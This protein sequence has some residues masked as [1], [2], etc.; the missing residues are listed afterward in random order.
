GRGLTGRGGAAP[1]GSPRPV[2]PAGSGFRRGAGQGV[3]GSGPAGPRQEVVLLPRPRRSSREARTSRPREPGVTQLS[4]LA[5]EPASLRKPRAPGPHSQVQAGE[6]RL[7][8][9]VSSPPL[10]QKP[11]GWRHPHPEWLFPV[12]VTGLLKE[13]DRGRT[14]DSLQSCTARD[15]C[16]LCYSALEPVDYGLKLLQTITEKSTGHL[17][18]HLKKCVCLSDSGATEMEPFVL[19]PDTVKS[20]RAKIVTFIFWGK[21]NGV[22]VSGS[23]SHTVQWDA[24]SSFDRQWAV[25]F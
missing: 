1:P 16:L 19:A 21:N 11:I 4:V 17:E 14:W 2:R 24:D 25:L 18:P 22:S 8:G 7:P 23:P 12:Q 6:V 10:S 3:P 15:V 20:M 13:H 9:G 5:L